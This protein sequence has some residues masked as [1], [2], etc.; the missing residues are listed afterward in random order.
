MTTITHSVLDKPRTE[1]ENL[2]QKIRDGAGLAGPLIMEQLLAISNEIPQNINQ[3]NPSY[4][5]HLANR[6]LE[7]ARLAIEL[8]AI[9]ERYELNKEALRK[10]EQSTAQ[11]IRAGVNGY[12]TVADRQ[13]YIH[14]DLQYLEA[15]MAAN[16]AKVF[17]KAVEDNYELFIRHHYSLR[18]VAEVDETMKNAESREVL[19]DVEPKKDVWEDILAM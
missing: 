17:R 13:A 11:L 12:K 9:A 10:K 3:I 4:A 15:E 1:L 16:E 5:R 6:M 18:K 14:L 19:Q 7:G 2:E 8:K